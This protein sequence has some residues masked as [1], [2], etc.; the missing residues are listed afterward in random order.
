MK[1]IRIG[2][3]CGKSGIKDNPKPMLIKVRVKVMILRR[4]GSSARSLASF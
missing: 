4:L 1:E 2:R 3:G